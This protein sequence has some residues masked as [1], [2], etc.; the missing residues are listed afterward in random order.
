M[1]VNKHYIQ[2]CLDS[3]QFKKNVSYDDGIIRLELVDPPCICI[4]V[5]N[6]YDSDMHIVVRDEYF[7]CNWFVSKGVTVFNEERQVVPPY[8]SLIRCN[9]PVKGINMT[10]YLYPA[11]GLEKRKIE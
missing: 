2:S 8:Y 4:G 6:K 10:T 9:K 11:T 7:D 3:E 1:D 5:L